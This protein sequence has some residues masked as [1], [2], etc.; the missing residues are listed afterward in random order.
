MG[1][2]Y[3]AKPAT[4]Q[5]LQSEQT[6]NDEIYRN[7]LL[8]S[9]LPKELEK[10]DLEEEPLQ[11]RTHKRQQQEL[12][13]PLKESLLRLD[14]MMMRANPKMQK[15]LKRT[16][17]VSDMI[18]GDI[19]LDEESAAELVRLYEENPQYL[20]L[21]YNGTDHSPIT[22]KK[23]QVDKRIKPKIIRSKWKNPI[24]Y[25]IEDAKNR[26]VV[27]M[28]IRIWEQ[29]TCLRFRERVFFFPPGIVFKGN[30]KGCWANVGKRVLTNNIVNLGPGCQNVGTVLHEMAHALGSYHEQN[31]PDRNEYITLLYQNIVPQ[32]L[33]NFIIKPYNPFGILSYYN[34]GSIMHYEDDDFAKSPGLKTFIAKR[35]YYEKTMGQTNAL[36]F[37]D[38]LPINYFYCHNKC[39]GAWT[40][41]KCKY[42]GYNDP[43]NCSK[44]KCP[45]A[46]GGE[47]C[48]G[49]RASRPLPTSCGEQLLTAIED[50]RTLRSP[51]YSS[52][53]YGRGSECSWI[54]KA[55]QGKRVQLSFQG[56]F[57]IA[58]HKVCQDF[59][60]VRLNRFL[61]TGPRF[62]C[63]NRP[64]AIL[65][66]DRGVMIVL[67]RSYSGPRPGQSKRGF[68]ARYRYV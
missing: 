67:F 68:E 48:T 32:Q 21:E 50:Y 59:V 10:Q 43:N 46:F 51:G 2:I 64:T 65:T 30:K 19:K 27:K 34:Y 54:I 4:S 31:R 1:V 22:T 29:E 18:D 53:G 33:M 17:D 45:D 35:P 15:I 6:S 20:N 28:A 58:C 26:A 9:T 39:A 49:I 14:E 41:S 8:N 36:S 62:C 12:V 56:A 61:V 13:P 40:A 63:S 52:E 57:D 47:N 11:Q 44:C 42:G 37:Y 55:P 25:H 5:S 38:L 23:I 24:N 60:E 16:S 3:H 66:S 7:G